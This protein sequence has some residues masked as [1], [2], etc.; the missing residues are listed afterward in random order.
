M[1]ANPIAQGG[2]QLA[3]TI[4]TRRGQIRYAVYTIAAMAL[5][6]MLR[7]GDDDD[8]LGANRMDEAGNFNLYRNILIPMGNGQYFKV[9]VGFGMQQLAWAHGVNAV[10]TLSGQMT[11][12]EAIAESAGLW[13]RSAMPVAP[14]LSHKKLTCLSVKI[15]F[16]GLSTCLLYT[17][18]SPRDRT[19]SRMPSSA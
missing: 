14:R 19:R 13:A 2:H 9:P 8:E 7:S 16:F 10:R 15:S 17:S 6:A 4:G 5:Y 1:F 3:M 18:P 12:G 11:A